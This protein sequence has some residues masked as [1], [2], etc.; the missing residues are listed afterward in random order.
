MRRQ[1]ALSL[2][3]VS[4]LAFPPPF[5]AAQAGGGPPSH[6]SPP[7]GDQA[8]PSGMTLTVAT[9]LVQ[10]DVV[11]QD[12]A[13]HPVHGLKLSDFQVAEDKKPQSVKNFEEHI[14]VDPGQAKPAPAVKLGPGMFT[15]YTPVPQNAP[16]TVILLDRLN[17][18]M[19]GQ[20]DGLRQ[21]RQFLKNADPNSRVAIFG[22]TSRLIMLQ[23]FTSDPAVLRD[24]LEHKIGAQASVILPTGGEDSLSESAADAGAPA[25]TVANLRQFESEAAS[26]QT[27]LGINLTLT[28]F[29]Q[30]AGY[31]SGFPG[32]KNL[33]W[34]SGSFPIYVAPD[35]TIQYSFNTEATFNDPFRKMV[36]LLARARVAVYPIDVNG[37]VPTGLSFSQ[38]GRAYTQANPAAMVRDIQNTGIHQNDLHNTM[39]QLATDTGGRAF[40]NSNDLIGAFADSVKSGSDYYTLTYS[41]TN[42]DPR[43]GFR[44]IHVELTG[45]ANSRGLKLAY[46]RGYFLDDSRHAVS[47]AAK[48]AAPGPAPDPYALAA[49]QHGAPAP[50]EILFKVRV[51]PAAKST[52]DSADAH[53]PPALPRYDIGFTAL[54]GK[55]DI[56]IQA[57]GRHHGAIE[58]VTFIYDRDGK[59]LDT[60]NQTMRFNLTQ[61]NYDKLLKGGIGYSQQ[62][63]T[64]A[65]AQ[66]LRIAI[67]DLVSGRLGA[68]EVPLAAVSHLDPAP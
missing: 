49:M 24:A 22:L 40:Y 11:V 9:Q 56:P 32:R 15:D 54:A 52:E 42:H 50:S 17:T 66:S 36:N 26:Y 5:C 39:N 58:F 60:Q 25:S 55:I 44:S 61:E 27:Q 45:E 62:V 19:S 31:L 47:I 67:H 65:R 10:V 20:V 57:D 23:G 59:L 7:G 12:S 51:L 8:S 53:H 48:N 1:L 37:L 4:A 3:I 41:P 28:A 30:L 13:G 2:L 33:L 34:L 29:N 63:T 14:F 68:V 18:P 64:P 21:L 35:P 43:G 6:Q 46:R 38:D 16:L